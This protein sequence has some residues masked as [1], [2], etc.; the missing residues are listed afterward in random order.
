MSQQTCY[1]NNVTLTTSQQTCN[2][3]NATVTMSQI[4]IKLIFHYKYVKIKMYHK[5]IHGKDIYFYMSKV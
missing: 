5:H 4:H 3:N 1:N 2:T